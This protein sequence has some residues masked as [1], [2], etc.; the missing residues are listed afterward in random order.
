MPNIK[1]LKNIFIQA[2]ENEVGSCLKG[3]GQ[4]EKQGDFV[5]RKLQSL[6]KYNHFLLCYTF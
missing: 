1:I 4:P 3:Q 2:Q 5:T 6:R